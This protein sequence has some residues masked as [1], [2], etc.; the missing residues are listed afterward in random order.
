MK[1]LAEI[2]LALVMLGGCRMAAPAAPQDFSAARP[3]GPAGIV[4]STTAQPAPNPLPPAA[5]VTPRV[6]S[7]VSTT[8]PPLASPVTA[9][10]PPVSPAAPA[11]STVPPPVVSQPPA[12]GDK[13]AATGYTTIPWPVP[14]PPGPL[15]QNAAPAARLP[16]SLPSSPST[17]VSPAGGLAPGGTSTTAAAEPPKPDWSFLKA[18]TSEPAA[19]DHVPVPT[20]GVSQA[21]APAAPPATGLALPATAESYSKVALPAPPPPPSTPA[22]VSQPAALPAPA[23]GAGPAPSDIRLVNSKRVSF[24]YEVKNVGSSG[25]TAVELWCTRDGRS[26][27]KLK[28]FEQAHPPCVFEV[29]EEDLYGFTLVV[30]SGVGL[31]RPPQEGDKPQ[32]WVEVDTTRPVVRL[33]GVEA[34]PAASGRSLA[35]RWKATDKNLGPRPINLLYATQAAGPWKPIATRVENTGH[36]VWQIPSDVPHHLLVRVEAV[37]LVGNLGMAQT[38]NPLLDDLSQ[39]T[40]SILAVEGTGK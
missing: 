33:M 39:P 22:V 11:A 34:G 12:R 37:D 15:A 13:Q 16:E 20:G 29:D 1:P 5:P 14:A 7:V 24:N 17:P 21:A 23:A 8:T 26:W 6:E 27:K 28:T 30:R 35:I 40:A 36:Y 25:V 3:T 31:G 10:A 38:T 18:G 19:P 9:S 2:G 32:V 4:V